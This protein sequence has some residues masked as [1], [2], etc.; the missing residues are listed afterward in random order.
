MY[1]QAATSF[2]ANGILIELTCRVHERRRLGVHNCESDV[3]I[4]HMYIT[5][6]I[7]LGIPKRRKGNLQQSCSLNWFIAR[8]HFFRLI[9]RISILISLLSKW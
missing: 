2:I 7:I 6:L 1:L 9:Y 5:A 4:V 8:L 3:D